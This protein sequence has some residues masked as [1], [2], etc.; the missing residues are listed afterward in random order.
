MGI[1]FKK[2]RSFKNEKFE[3]IP[4]VGDRTKT[5]KG[6]DG[7]DE[8]TVKIQ[9]IDQRCMRRCDPKQEKKIQK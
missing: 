1:K 9:K 7:F 4:L 3:N 5:K 2:I 6:M 8:A